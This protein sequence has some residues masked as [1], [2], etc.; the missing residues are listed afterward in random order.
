[1]GK[2]NKKCSKI[3]IV[4]TVLIVIIMGIIYFFNK[5]VSDRIDEFT[6]GA[7]LNMTYK[8]MLTDSATREMKEGFKLIKRFSLDEGSLIGRTDKKSLYME[9]IPS[10][11][12]LKLTD[13]YVLSDEKM[14]NVSAVYDYLLSVVLADHPFISMIIPEWKLGSYITE[15]Q[16]NDI[17][18]IETEAASQK[19]DGIQ[20]QDNGFSLAAG[21]YIQDLSAAFLISK[22]QK[23]DFEKTE[24]NDGLIDYSYYKVNKAITNEKDILIGIN[25]K[26]LFEDSTQFHV[27]I[28]DEAKGVQLKLRGDVTPKE[29][30]VKIPTDIM[31]DEEIEVFKTIKT[32]IDAIIDENY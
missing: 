16:M 22:F 24:Y 31:S 28:T 2:S 17:I 11:S 32:T 13:C 1:M 19:S 30:T 9:L 26:T 3:I 10:G 27:I 21:M 6:A 20:P 25:L 8:V 18:G 7:T 14:I 5:K 15:S 12:E 23:N 29:N 4:I